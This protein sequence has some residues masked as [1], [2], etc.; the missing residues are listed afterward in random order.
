MVVL[1]NACTIATDNN[2]AAARVAGSIITAVFHHLAFLVLLLL[3]EWKR[4]DVV[5]WWW[6][7]NCNTGPSKYRHST[8]QLNNEQRARKMR[9]RISAS[10][11]KNASNFKTIL[12]DSDLGRDESFEKPTGTRARRHKSRRHPVQILHRAKSGT[13]PPAS[14]SLT[15]IVLS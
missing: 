11:A 13:L 2:V 5:V 4:V 8:Q 15:E 10:F 3:T 1:S 14:L 9:T 6:I 12:Q 7:R